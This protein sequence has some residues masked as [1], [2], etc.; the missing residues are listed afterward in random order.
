[1]EVRQGKPE[2][3]HEPRDERVCG[4]RI[5]ALAIDRRTV[6]R[7]R[8]ETNRRSK[9][10]IVRIPHSR[11]LQ[12]ELLVLRDRRETEIDPLEKRFS[13]NIEPHQV[14]PQPVR[15]IPSIS[16]DAEE[17]RRHKRPAV[18]RQG[19]RTARFDGNLRPGEVP[20]R[21]RYK[22]PNLRVTIPPRDEG[23]RLFPQCGHRN[24][25]LPCEYPAVLHLDPAADGSGDPGDSGILRYRR[26]HRDPPCVQQAHLPPSNDEA[27]HT[28]LTVKA[29]GLD[30]PRRVSSP[31]CGNGKTQRV[32]IMPA[33]YEINP[34]NRISKHPICGSPQM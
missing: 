24:T 12:K 27:D 34:R 18:H 22:I 29:G 4:N 3:L 31:L 26:I 20:E 32:M 23:S 11:D 2:A 33:D 13:G 9:V 28:H 19:S 6:D 17:I 1:M 21:V 16:D 25:H 30:N 10:G 14:I 8:N 7:R 15:R 5:D